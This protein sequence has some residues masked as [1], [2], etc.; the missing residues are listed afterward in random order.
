MWDKIWNWFLFELLITVE[1]WNILVFWV[2]VYFSIDML[3][4]EFE[5]KDKPK[6]FVNRLWL[7][8]S[9][10][11]IWVFLL[12][13]LRITVIFQHNLCISEYLYLSAIFF[14]IYSI[15]F[16]FIYIVITQI[17]RGRDNLKIQV[18]EFLILIISLL[19]LGYN[20]FYFI[21]YVYL[22]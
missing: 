3:F 18:V 4:D 17:R 9:K 19:I 10:I 8:L 6:V 5:R 11:N 12:F 2:L 1:F 21:Y 16:F 14:C 20:G 7:Y 15:W 13:V 22:M